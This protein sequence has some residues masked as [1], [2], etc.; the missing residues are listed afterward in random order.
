MNMAFFPIV[1]RAAFSEVWLQVSWTKATRLNMHNRDPIA[2]DS[3]LMMTRTI[4]QPR[5]QHAVGEY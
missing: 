4:V 2:E 5:P 1:S 3:Q